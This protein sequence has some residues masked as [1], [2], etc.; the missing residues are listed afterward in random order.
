MILGIDASNIRTGGGVTHLV[1][2]LRAA[3]PEQSGFEKVIVWGGSNTLNKIDEKPWLV[4]IQEPMLDKSLFHR[5]FWQKFYLSKLAQKA[6]CNILFIPGGTYSGKFRPF[7][8]MSQN[9]LPFEWKDRKRY[10]FSLFAFKLFLLKFTQ[11]NTF[12]KAN[13]VIFLTNYARKVVLDLCFLSLDKT[14]I[15]H[16]GINKKFYSEPKIPKNKNEVSLGN[17]LKVLYVS[18]IGKYKHQWNVVDA[19]GIL[20]RKNYPVE[21]SLVGS[22]DEKDAFKKLEDT[23]KKVDNEG[24]FIKYFSKVSYSEIEAKYKEADIF[25]FASSCETFG[26]ILTEAMAAGL[27]IACSNLSAM[28]ELLGDA[29]V[30]FNP[31]QPEEI[32]NALER[33]IN[34]VELRH[35]LSNLAF[36]KSK[37]FSWEK[38]ASDTF[39]FL[40]LVTKQ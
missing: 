12:K 40:E 38:S 22:P 1:E 3:K 35:K 24:K 8:T 4:K 30:Y 16:H 17:P 37:N 20:K 18:F 7:V 21:L 34:S 5:S 15:I 6:N 23:I 29:G 9:L 10:G 36:E 28:P 33:L 32:A 26:Q 25:V 39:R 19:I 31:E 14:V 13:G 27:P 2:L 11:L